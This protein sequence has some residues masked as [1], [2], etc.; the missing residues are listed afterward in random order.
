MRL[1][2]FPYA[3]LLLPPGDLPLTSGEDLAQEDCREGLWDPIRQGLPASP[4]RAVQFPNLEAWHT[5]LCVRGFILSLV[6][7]ALL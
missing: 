7:S 4:T 5:R 6:S 1:S 3:D 2:I